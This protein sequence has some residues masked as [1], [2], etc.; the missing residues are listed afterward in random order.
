MN[1]TKIKNSRFY[2]VLIYSKGKIYTH[3]TTCS[4]PVART[5]REGL[6]AE[7]KDSRIL[8][9]NMTIEFVK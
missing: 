2:E 3:F 9:H 6:K 8:K 1:E 4:L 5:V 7:G